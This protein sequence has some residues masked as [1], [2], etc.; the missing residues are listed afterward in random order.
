MVLLE[1]ASHTGLEL[2][3]TLDIERG[4]LRMC[5]VAYHVDP[6]SRHHCYDSTPHKTRGG[7][8]KGTTIL[9]SSLLGHR[10]KGLDTASI[11]DYRQ[12]LPEVR[13]PSFLK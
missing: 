12:R 9:K 7:D 4:I 2:G 8:L 1:Q 13:I 11:F 6:C 3:W 10:L 5:D